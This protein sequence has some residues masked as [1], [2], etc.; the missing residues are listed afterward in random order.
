MITGSSGSAAKN[1][2]TH[3]GL[4]D[5]LN[6]PPGFAATGAAQIISRT[7]CLAGPYWGDVLAAAA[8]RGLARKVPGTG[9]EKLFPGRGSESGPLLTAELTYRYWAFA[10]KQAR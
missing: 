8:A 2:A 6:G 7:R 5:C 9:W 3:A 10:A 1:M 4:P